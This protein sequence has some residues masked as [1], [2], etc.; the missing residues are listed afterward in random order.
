MNFLTHFFLGGWG[1]TIFS[2]IFFGHGSSDSYIM[3]TKQH[4]L[5]LYMYLFAKI[6]S[7]PLDIYIYVSTGNKQGHLHFLWDIKGVIHCVA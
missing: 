7:C 1:G 4:K 6:I 3:M 2:L 5:N